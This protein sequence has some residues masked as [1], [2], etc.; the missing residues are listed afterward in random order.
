MQYITLSYVGSTKT[1]TARVTSTFV[2]YLANS[3]KLNVMVV[4][5]KNT[6]G[7]EVMAYMDSDKGTELRYNIRNKLVK[8]DGLRVA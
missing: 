7:T 8:V 2:V 6:H 5:Y 1:F 3:R 4:E